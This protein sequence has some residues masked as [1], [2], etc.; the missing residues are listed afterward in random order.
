MTGEYTRERV[1]ALNLERAAEE[2]TAAKTNKPKA[3]RGRAA[4]ELL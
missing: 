1:L 3:Q 4:G 2:E